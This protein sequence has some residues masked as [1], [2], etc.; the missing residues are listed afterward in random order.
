MRHDS[1]W[2]AVLCVLAHSLCKADKQHETESD[3]RDCVKRTQLESV[4]RV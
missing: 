1:N 4:P 3:V 2:V